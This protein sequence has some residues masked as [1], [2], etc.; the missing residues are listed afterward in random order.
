MIFWSGWFNLGFYL[1]LADKYSKVLLLSLFNDKSYNLLPLL[2]CLLLIV[3][4]L[5]LG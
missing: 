2:L 3:I 4:K 1:P 5:T